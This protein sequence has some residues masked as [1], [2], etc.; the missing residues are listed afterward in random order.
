MAPSYPRTANTG[1]P[2]SEKTSYEFND[3]ERYGFVSSGDSDWNDRNDWNDHNDYYPF[4]NAYSYYDDDYLDD[5]E[6]AYED[7]VDDV[8]DYLEDHDEGS[9]WGFNSYYW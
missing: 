1:S 4:Y 3:S 5:L 6:D 2:V 9:Y 7:Y 8:E